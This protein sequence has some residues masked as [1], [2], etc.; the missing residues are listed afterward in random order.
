MW[1]IIRRF[2]PDNQNGSRII[3]TTRFQSVAM[4][5]SSHESHDYIHHVKELSDDEPKK[6][7]EKSLSEC[8]GIGSSQLDED[9]I[10]EIKNGA[11]TNLHILSGIEIAEG[12]NVAANLHDFTGLRKLAIYKLHKDQT[13]FKDV[14][15]SIQYLGGYSLQSLVID[16]ESS[17][18]LSTLDTMSAPPTYLSALELSGKLLK[19]PEW[20]PNL[21]ELTKLTLSVTVL[22]TDNLVVI[23]KLSSLFSLTFSI[24][25]TSDDPDIVAILE[26]NKSESRGEIFVPP[27]GFSKLKL[28]RIYV[29]LLPQ[30]NFSKNA[31]PQLERVELCFKRLEGILGLE[32]LGML[33]DVLLTVSAQATE[34]TKS[35]LEDLRRQS[36]KYTVVINEY[37]RMSTQHY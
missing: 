23:I 28:F 3:V 25:A 29:P 16:D 24:S 19:L 15:S 13:V 32:R 37:N 31:M 10:P 30:L 14:L 21:L 12:S 6:L 20:L 26:K 1:K 22:R 8:K 36:S 11:M 17:E 18:F 5:C 33:Q 27:G 35:I 34:P 4:T 2:F 7:F 9:K